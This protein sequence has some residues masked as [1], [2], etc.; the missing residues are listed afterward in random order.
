MADPTENPEPSVCYHYPGE[1]PD[2]D[3]HRPYKPDDGMHQAEVPDR[4]VR[5]RWE[6]IIRYSVYFTGGLGTGAA[7]MSAFFMNQAATAAM[8][9]LSI[10]E[11][12]D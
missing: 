2:A 10:A 3:V 5:L 12:N 4:A 6:R 8:K 9:A 1:D 7:A 11:K